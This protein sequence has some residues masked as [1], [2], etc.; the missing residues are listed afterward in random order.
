MVLLSDSIS[1]E[2]EKLVMEYVL[3]LLLSL[4]NL[5]ALFSLLL[6]PFL[7]FLIVPMFVKFVIVL[8]PCPV[9]KT[10]DCP[11]EVSVPWFVMVGIV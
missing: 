8:L 11:S 3:C 1:P 10:V 9:I 5:I 4:L 6:S 2:F 7:V